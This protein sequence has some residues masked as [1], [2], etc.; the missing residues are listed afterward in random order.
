MKQLTF[1]IGVAAAI[2]AA[3]YHH[4]ADAQAAVQPVAP[5]RFMYVDGEVGQ[6][7]V[8]E[9]TNSVTLAAA[10]KI[11][12]GFTKF[13]DRSRVTVIRA[14]KSKKVYSLKGKESGPEIE[15]GDMVFVAR[16][17]NR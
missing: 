1:L 9:W 11:S 8:K 12:G 15:A 3:F 7:G 13:A 17:P 5:V 6:R 14:D 4:N 16:L 10:I 2:A